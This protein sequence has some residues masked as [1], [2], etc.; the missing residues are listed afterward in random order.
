MHL[1]ALHVR[2]WIETLTDLK[3]TMQVQVVA[4]HVRAWIETEIANNAY[5]RLKVALH[6]RAWIETINIAKLSERAKSPS[7]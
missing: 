1:V 4:L 3:G 6:V 2:A 5:S 7:M